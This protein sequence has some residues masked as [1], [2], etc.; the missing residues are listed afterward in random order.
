[1]SRK[2]MGRPGGYEHLVKGYADQNHQLSNDNLL[3]DMSH[4]TLTFKELLYLMLIVLM[5]GILMGM[6]C[7]YCYNSMQ[8]TKAMQIETD[9]SDSSDAELSEF[10][11]ANAN[12]A[13]NIVNE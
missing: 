1:M 11:D 2:L 7:M 13:I 3:D 10:A 5:I 8:Q 9:Q 6:A 4:M 12:V